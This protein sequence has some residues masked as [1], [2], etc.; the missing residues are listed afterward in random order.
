MLTTDL[1][2]SQKITVNNAAEHVDHST[3]SSGLD[4]INTSGDAVFEQ[5]DNFTIESAAIIFPESFTIWKKITSSS[6]YALPS[7]AIVLTGVNSHT[8]YPI[9][10]LGPYAALRLPME[11]Y[12][13]ALNLFVNVVEMGIAEPFTISTSGLYDCPVS[14]LLAPSALNGKV[15]TVAPFIKVLHNKPMYTPVP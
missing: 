14:M 12:E 4:L 15:L 5:G 2:D 8:V 6:V 1:S 3:L 10:V 11:N 7:I 13:L 9:E